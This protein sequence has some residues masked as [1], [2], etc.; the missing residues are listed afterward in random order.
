MA[1][2]NFGSGDLII[3]PPAG[4]AD[5]TPVRVGVLQDISLDY[6]SSIKLLFGQNQF[7]IE[8]ANAEGKLGGKAKFGKIDGR[9]VNSVLA[10][11][12]IAPGSKIKVDEPLVVAAGTVTV[13]GAAT[14]VDDMGVYDSTGQPYTKVTTAPVGTQYSVNPATGVYTFNVTQNGLTLTF[15]YSKTQTA[16]KTITLGNPYQGIATKFVL[17]CFNFTAVNLGKVLGAKLFAAV[18]PKLA[19]PFKNTDFTIPDIDFECLDNGSGQL[20]EIYIND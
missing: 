16:G 13:T 20:G 12:T 11:S 6:S 9:L 2:A 19:L 15:R 7:A 5:P 18:F 4:A 3:L 17:E 1:Q 8:A 14:F 10:G